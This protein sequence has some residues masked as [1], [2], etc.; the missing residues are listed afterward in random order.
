MTEACHGR[1]RYSHSVRVES[2]RVKIDNP[3]PSLEHRLVE[4][5]P[6][7]MIVSP[8]SMSLLLHGASVPNP[9]TERSD[10]CVELLDPGSQRSAVQ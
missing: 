8:Q 9:G 6:R 1:V 7:D 10:K 4:L 3:E 5:V 2:S